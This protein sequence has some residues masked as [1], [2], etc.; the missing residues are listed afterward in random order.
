MRYLFDWLLGTSHRKELLDKIEEQRKE[1]RI[2]EARLDKRIAAL[3][4]E[5]GWFER[6]CREHIAKQDS[7]KGESKGIKVPHGIV[8]ASPLINSPR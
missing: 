3:D 2:H 6:T 1:L 4:G 5:T 7:I 8:P